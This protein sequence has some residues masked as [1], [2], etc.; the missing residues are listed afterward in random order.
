MAEKT[1][2]ESKKETKKEPSKAKVE[3][4]PSAKGV[5]HY[6]KKAWLNPTEQN[7]QDL[8]SKMI[9]WRAGNR[10]T[11]LEKP[12]RLD[13]ARAL[14]YKAKKGFVVFRIVIER[15]GRFKN[16]PNTKRRSKRFN[17][18]KILKMNYQ[19]VAEQRVQNKYTNLEVLNSYKIAKDGRFYFFEVICID[20][21]RPEIKNDSNFRWLQN[22]TNRHRV[23]RGL[24]SA[25][26]KSRGLRV[27]ASNLK[28]R[29]SGNANKHH[30]K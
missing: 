16:R 10:I 19:W 25:G 2:A 27:K 21:E 29:P 5:Y 18:K 20:P 4:K 9:S 28:V 24:T 13:R 6:L 11:K 17:I 15:G 12:T 14:G 30:G 8:R 23:Y 3:Q 26:R 22:P 1:K 7:T